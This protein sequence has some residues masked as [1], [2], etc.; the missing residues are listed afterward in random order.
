M[1]ILDQLKGKKKVNVLEAELT[2]AQSEPVISHKTYQMKFMFDW[3]SG[4]CVWTTN[5]AA[6]NLYGGYPVLTEQLPVSAQLKAA[7]DRLIDK[8]DEAL[9]WDYPPNALLWNEAQ[10][11]AFEAEAI[12]AYKQLC[13]ELGEEYEVVLWPNLDK[14]E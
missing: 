2:G 5:D 1:G 9:D 11:E 10:V 13:I 7:L 8:H 3:G 14:V 4:C 12:A 6:R